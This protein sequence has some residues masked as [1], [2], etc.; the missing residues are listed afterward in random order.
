[1]EKFVQ[2]IN[3]QSY[4]TDQY[5]KASICSL[6][7]L[8]LE[9]AWAHARVMDW[10]YDR[11]QS[12]NMFWVLSRMYVIIES[13]P[14]WQDEIILNTWS[15]GTDGMF[16]YREFIIENA[17]GKVLLRA[18]TAWL[19][20]DHETKKVIL[21]RDYVGTFPRREGI[22]ACRE[23]ERIRPRK[24][25]PPKVFLPVLF[26]DLDINR[27]FNSV[28]SLERVLDHFGVEFLNQYEPA[29]IEVNYLK[30][31]FAGDCLAVATE[32][33]VENIYQ[34]T[35]VREKDLSGLSTMKINWRERNS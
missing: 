5:G 1:M 32:K 3:I 20:L 31:G 7:Q 4:H 9:A 13:Y 33:S 28:K 11:L 23:P 26:S 30:E 22:R 15:A 19:I 25:T 29:S 12:N 18:N 17:A 21:L 35:I 2:K 6:F 16:A 8:M 10:G 24:T 14:S 34:S 27:H